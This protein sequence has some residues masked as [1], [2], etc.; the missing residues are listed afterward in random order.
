M[1]E[2]VYTC[3]STEQSSTWVCAF[4]LAF[5]AGRHAHMMHRRNLT[6]HLQ[7]DI[8]LYICLVTSRRL[9]ACVCVL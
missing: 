3:N 2:A 6:R 4:T 7:E 1:K 5:G 9:L 8:T